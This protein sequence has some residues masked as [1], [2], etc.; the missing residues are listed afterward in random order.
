MEVRTRNSLLRWLTLYIDPTAVRDS[1]GEAAEALRKESRAGF[2]PDVIDA[3][4]RSAKTT[5]GTTMTPN[6]V[7]LARAL[8]AEIVSLRAK[9]DEVDA[10]LREH[11]AATPERAPLVAMLAPTTTAVLLAR[12]GDPTDYASAAALEKACGL[13]LK[14]HSS[15]TQKGGVHLTKRGPGQVRK[16]LFLLA[17]RMIGSNA[18]GRAWCQRRHSYRPDQKLSAVIAVVRKL[19]KAIWHVAR[20]ASF[21]VGKC[22]E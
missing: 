3:I 11:L 14:E 21:E 8:M 20:G 17:L 5:Q 2:K 10:R 16:Y 4:V 13:N 18:V 19:V 22:P 6:E 7:A 1:P 15:G 9:C 12:V